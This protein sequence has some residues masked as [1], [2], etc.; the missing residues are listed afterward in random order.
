MEASTA[1]APAATSCGPYRTAPLAEAP[2]APRPRALTLAT[3]ALSLLAFATTLTSVQLTRALVGVLRQASTARRPVPRARP[4]LGLVQAA[5]DL[6]RRNR[7]PLFIDPTLDT[8]AL[9]V[10]VPEVVDGTVRASVRALDDYAATRGLWFHEVG[11]V[12]RLERAV[13]AADLVCVDTLDA[14]ATRL[15][16]LAAVTVERPA[17]ASERRVRLRLTRDRPALESARADF[18]AA[19]YDVDVVGRTLF[20]SERSPA[21]PAVAEGQGLPGIRPLGRGVF[22]VTRG[23]VEAMLSDQ[24]TLLRRVRIEPVSRAGRVVGVCVFGVGPGSLLA[25]LG[26]QSGD[27]ILRVN[28]FE[29]ASPDR[30]LAAYARLRTADTLTVTIERDG[31]PITLLYAIV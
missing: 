3:W 14:C 2:P 29:V 23:A 17:S 31:R 5:E 28:G 22:V 11:G 20:V 6:A 1:P 21:T 10:R 12:L 9:G 7:V 25:G 15:E 26:L 4:A 8:G 30:C 19:G 18:V 24:S 13:S 16:R 27:V